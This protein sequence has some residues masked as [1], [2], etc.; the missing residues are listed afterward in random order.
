MMVFGGLF[1]LAAFVLSIAALVGLVSPGWFVR[2]SK[3]GKVYNR[4]LL[5]L[6][7]N[8]ASVVAMFYGV[9]ITSA[10][11]FSAA[12]GGVL[13]LS[14]LLLLICSVVGL[15]FPGLFARFSRSG[16][17]FSRSSLFLG[18]FLSAF[19]SLFVGALLMPTTP[20]TEAVSTPQPNY[21]DAAPASQPASAAVVGLMAAAD[22]RPAAEI[23]STASA[24]TQNVAQQT[25][26]TAASENSPA[27]EHTCRV[28][29]IKDGDTFTCLTN[30]RRQVTVRMAQID[31]P[32]KG[33]PFG[34]KAK[35]TLSEYIYGQ[36]VR[37]EESGFD[38]YGRT[39]A[40]VYDESGQN[41][42]MLMVQAG[43]AWAYK[44]YMT[45][46]AYQEMQDEATRENLGLWSEN[47]YIYPSDW[48]RGVRPQR[49]Q[50]A[51]L[52]T[53]EPHQQRSGRLAQER[54]AR[55]FSCGSKRFCREMNS[56]AE[57]MFYLRQCGVRRLDGDNDGIPCES[58]C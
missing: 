47:G 52:P 19:C 4:F 29:G 17:G 49:E 26:E 34:Q 13:I 18:F 38:R 33:Q 3:T 27:A 56:C 2:F 57:A 25:A 14:S 23:A 24:T 1:M 7:F 41:I 55:G 42:N 58:I 9:A 30:G 21:A 50:V 44:E 11:S 31:A 36:T 32:E 43:M 16:K 15:V 53:A 28:V 48:R 54:N 6:G 8:A 12:I 10:A 37:L 20:N 39:L 46:T 35:S 51:T 45:N 22:T 5:F 40:E